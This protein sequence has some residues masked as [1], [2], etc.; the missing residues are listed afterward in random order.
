MRTLTVGLA[1][2]CVILYYVSFGCTPSNCFVPISIWWLTSEIRAEM[3]VSFH[4]RCWVLTGIRIANSMQQSPSLEVKQ[5]LSQ[6][7]PRI[8]WNPKVHYRVHNS[9][10]LVRIL[11]QL[12]PVHIPTSPFLKIH[13]NIILPFPPGSPKL[14]L[15]PRSSSPPNPVC[16][17][18]LPHTC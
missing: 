11:S 10:P 14:S 7:I 15:S 2:G 6:E 9:P 17:S 5:F 3:H 12:D 8:L 4:V 16:T 18:P 13:L 1:K